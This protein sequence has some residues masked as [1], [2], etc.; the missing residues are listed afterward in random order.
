MVLLWLRSGKQD[1]RLQAAAILGDLPK[2]SP[3]VVAALKGAV[4]DPHPGVS[5]AA[6]RALTV[7]REKARQAGLTPPVIVPDEPSLGGQSL[8]EWLCRTEAV[9]PASEAA[10]AVR[11]MGTNAIPALLW[12]LTYRDPEFG[13]ADNDLCWRAKLGFRLLGKAGWPALPKLEGFIKGQDE[14]L[15]QAAFHAAASMGIS[16][17]VLNA[18]RSK[19]GQERIAAENPAPD[20][21]PGAADNGAMK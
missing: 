3:V 2:P 8:T 18:L 14:P 7:Q 11:E 12:M 17:D 13:V 10:K 6:T 9:D 16:Y 15:A 4:A 21:A 20:T 19:S 5:Q 1:R